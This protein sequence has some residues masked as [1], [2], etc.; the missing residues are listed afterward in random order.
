MCKPAVEL[1]IEEKNNNIL[2]SSRDKTTDLEHKY[3]REK[4]QNHKKY[5]VQSNVIKSESQSQEESPS[6]DKLIEVRFA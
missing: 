6:K 2:T 5:N 1:P 4:Y 3:N